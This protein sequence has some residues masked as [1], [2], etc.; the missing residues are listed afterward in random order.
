MELAAWTCRAVRWVQRSGTP[1]CL[2][3]LVQGSP[4]GG[5]RRAARAAIAD[6]RVAIEGA[7]VERRAA[8][9]A[10]RAARASSNLVVSAH[11]A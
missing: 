6:A 5:A 8:V 4:S 2:W 3:G 9:R 10:G 7:H 1:W 11:K